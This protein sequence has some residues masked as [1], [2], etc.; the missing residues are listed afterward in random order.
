MSFSDRLT[1]VFLFTT[2]DLG[3]EVTG[4]LCSNVYHV[5]VQTLFPKQK[6]HNFAKN[7]QW[8]FCDVINSDMNLSL[9]KLLIA[10]NTS[11]I[12]KTLFAYLFIF[13]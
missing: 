4:D 11:V 8:M 7:T 6:L 13:L 9:M 10:A 2:N 5:K 12:L 3:Y 1:Q